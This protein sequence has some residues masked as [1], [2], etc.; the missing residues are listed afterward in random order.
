MS[1]GD[2]TAGRRRLYSPSTR[3][4]KG[5]TSRPLTEHLNIA[6]PFSRGGTVSSSDR[7]D[8]RGRSRGSHLSWR[9]N[10]RSLSPRNRPIR[11]E[12]S[13]RVRS[14]DSSGSER[15]G[16]S[17]RSERREPS[18]GSMDTDMDGPLH[19]ERQHTEIEMVLTRPP[20]Q[21][22]M[23]PVPNRARTL[24]PHVETVARNLIQ[25]W[26]DKSLEPSPGYSPYE[27]LPWNHK[28]LSEGKLVCST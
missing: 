5:S 9:R 21:F 22:G 1:L 3:Y 10:S 2:S 4:S 12:P 20:S 13:L 24:Y 18:L 11:R 6:G 15:S 7:E 19:R 28:W 23:I 8:Y 26:S 17:Y 25:T 16:M 27:D 14:T